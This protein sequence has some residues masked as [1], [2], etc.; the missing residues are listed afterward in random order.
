MQ[1]TCMIARENDDTS[2]GAVVS[3]LC[4]LINFAKCVIIE[5]LLLLLSLL[6]SSLCCCS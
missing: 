2:L 5:L 6:L 4:H 3:E 1:N